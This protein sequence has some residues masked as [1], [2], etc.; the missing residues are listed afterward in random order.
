MLG[1]TNPAAVNYNPFATED[2]GSCVYLHKLN[3]VCYA[4]EDAEVVAED[5]GFTISWSLTEKCWAYFHTYKPDFYINLR[6]ALYSLKQGSIYKHNA[7]APGQYYGPKEPWFID[8]VFPFTAESLLNAI[9][10]VSEVF[11]SSGI[12]QQDQTITHITASNSNQCTGKLEIGKA[13]D[14]IVQTT[15]RSKGT[16]SFNDLRDAVSTHGQAFLDT[17]E[18]DFRP[19]Q[20]NLNFNKPFFKQELLADNYVIIRLEYDNESGNKVLLHDAA[21]DSQPTYI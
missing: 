15:A 19:L 6:N 13:L 16:W 14:K 21:V 7:G 8:L 20:G 3:G 18:K 5:K 4:F 9:V 12:E 1:C 2:N 10:W 11:S 17:I